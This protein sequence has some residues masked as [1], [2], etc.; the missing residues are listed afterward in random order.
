MDNYKI[1]ITSK[2]QLD[3]SDCVSFVIRISKEAATKLAD[4]IFSAINSLSTLPERNPIFDMPKPFPFIIRKHVVNNRY[5]LLYSIEN[6]NVVI[7]RIID[8]RRK[9]DYLIK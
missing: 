4:D 6:K 3:L 7:Y 9:F 5:V 1:I 2:A 8:S